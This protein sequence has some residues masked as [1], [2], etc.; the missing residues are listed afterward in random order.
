MSI[1]NDLSAFHAILKSH[2]K[3]T[4][5]A[6]T[7]VF[8]ALW[9]QPPLSMKELEKRLDGRIDRAS[10]YRVIELFIELR[11]VEKLY[12]GWKYRIELSE[13]FHPH[14]HHMRCNKCGST[15]DFNE[16]DSMSEVIRAITKKYNFEASSHQFEIDGLCKNCQ[17]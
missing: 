16:P 17:A 4:T 2:Q 8:K 11:I 6:R 15:Y 3:S 9:R 5:R 12:Q 14:H 7:E 13:K 10:A 1:E